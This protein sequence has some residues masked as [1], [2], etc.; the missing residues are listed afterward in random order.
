M[1]FDGG[2]VA[3]AIDETGVVYFF[4]GEQTR[5]V[6]WEHVN[7]LYTFTVLRGIYAP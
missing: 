1:L 4:W 5:Y 2:F 7:M 3:E 6:Q